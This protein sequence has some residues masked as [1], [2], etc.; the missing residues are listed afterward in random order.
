MMINFTKREGPMRI[1]RSGPFARHVVNRQFYKERPLGAVVQQKSSGHIT[2][3][4]DVGI[5]GNRPGFPFFVILTP[6]GEMVSGE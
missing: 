3:T 5:P 6:F 4:L 1:P 2:S